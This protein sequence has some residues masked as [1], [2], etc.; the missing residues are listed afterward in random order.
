MRKILF[1]FIL[2]VSAPAFGQYN[3]LTDYCTLGAKQAAVQGLNSTNY[4]QG[5]IPRCTVTVYQTGTVTLATIYSNSTGT[6]LG[7]GF[8]ATTAGQWLFFAGKGCYDIVLS[9]GFSPNAY[10]SPVTLTGVCTAGA[11][12]GTVS[13]VGLSA[14]SIFTVSGSPVTGTGNL[15]FSLN[16]QTQGTFLG[17]PCSGSGS[18]AFRSLC[19][20]DIPSGFV[21]PITDNFLIGSTGLGN[22]N[23][24]S[25]VSP[26]NVVVTNPTGVQ[27]IN[28]SG[29]FSG[30]IYQGGHNWSEGSEHA[31]SLWCL[32]DESV[33]LSKLCAWDAATGS[34][35]PITLGQGGF[36]GWQPNDNANYSPSSGPNTSGIDTVIG[37]MGPGVLAV[38]TSGYPTPNANGT[39]AS[40]NNILSGSPLVVGTGRVS[41]GGTTAAASNCNQGGTLTSVAGCLIVNVAGTTRYVPYF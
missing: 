21:P 9:G 25:N 26:S 38:G 24:A 27:A 13:S 37:R 36:F 8:T 29:S 20:A 34:T 1:F 6:P 16:S 39:W 40:A 12:S 3:A 17:A 30:L 2:A 10:P 31:R 15:S 41:F 14:P 19:T 7:N 5:V 4:L 23:R 22:P 35:Y 33:P 18:P 32:S 28:S 11:G